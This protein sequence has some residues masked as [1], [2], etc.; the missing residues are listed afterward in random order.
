[1]AS[2]RL[3]FSPSKPSDAGPLRYGVTYHIQLDALMEVPLYLTVQPRLCWQTLRR[4]PGSAVIATVDSTEDSLWRIVSTNASQRF[5]MDGEPVPSDSC[6]L[7][8][9]VHTGRFLT[10]SRA[11][12]VRTLMG[13][14]FELGVER[15]QERTSK[16]MGE[17]MTW[18]FVQAV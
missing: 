8:L 11:F 15:N 6:V 1:M 13:L 4:S 12:P 3:V 17:A 2:N 16:E 18:Q 14:G 7:L 5:E 9:H 10:A